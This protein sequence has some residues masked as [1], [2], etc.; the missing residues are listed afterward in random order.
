MYHHRRFGKVLVACL[1]VVILLAHTGYGAPAKPL[2]SV[3]PEDSLVTVWSPDPDQLI[4]SINLFTPGP[5]ADIPMGEIT[6]GMTEFG[7]PQE[8]LNAPAALLVRARANWANKNEEPYI[9]LLFSVKDLDAVIGALGVPDP[10]GIYGT[11]PYM[12]S[13]QGY[14]AF[15][16]DKKALNALKVAKAKPY[17]PSDEAAKLMENAQIFAHVNIT[18]WLDA[19]EGELEDARKEIKTEIQQGLDAKL[20]GGELNPMHE[21]FTPVLKKLMPDAIDFFF[22]LIKE[23][24]SLDAAATFD[25]QGLRVMSATTVAE[26]GCIARYIVP[27][28]GLGELA[29]AL[30]VLDRFMMAFWMRYEEKVAETFL[31]D[32]ESIA[33]W[34]LN[35]LGGEAPEVDAAVKDLG[36]ILKGTMSLVTGQRASAVMNYSDGA[37]GFAEVIEVKKPDELRALNAKAIE[38]TNRFIDQFVKRA[39]ENELPFEFKY[40][41]EEEFKT[42]G[43]VKVDRVRVVFTAADPD[44]QAELDRAM[45]V[46][47]PEGLNYL[48][49]VVGEKFIVCLSEKAMERTIATVQG[50]PG[51]DLLADD[52][53]VK[54]MANKVGL[55]KDAIFMIVPARFLEMSVQMMMKMMPQGGQPPL[56][57]PFATPAVFGTKSIEG[58]ILRCDAYVPQACIAECMTVVMGIMMMMGGGPF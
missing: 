25:L 14:L 16:G 22:E 5:Q 54:S 40:I 24:K 38:V 6:A 47:G 4:K 51:A 2:I 32:Y 18:G 29:P 36:S 13:Y 11:D 41:Y 34:A 39:T 31:A 27:S 56:P 53:S 42:I 49:A 19:F 57:L 15:S 35:A 17:E 20:Q 45:S 1:P 21:T 43:G 8:I 58:R 30:P 26:K 37:M 46:Y 28:E 7:I 9:I 33:K 3:L 12:M 44:A 50:K 23:F 55:D 10:N 48:F 52:P